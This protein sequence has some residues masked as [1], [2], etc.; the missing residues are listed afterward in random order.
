M[1]F[2]RRVSTVR[3]SAVAIAGL[4]LAIAAQTGRG[5][6]IEYQLFERDGEKLELL[7][8]GKR[9]YAASDF[10][11]STHNR[12]GAFY[13]YQKQLP[14]AKGF[15]ISILD[16][17]DSHGGFGITLERMPPAD[18]GFS[19]EWYDPAALGQFVKRQGGGTINV[20]FAASTPPAEVLS[21]EFLDAAD[22]RH[23]A[24]GLTSLFG[25]GD[26]FV[27]RVK[28]GSVLELPPAGKGGGDRKGDGG[29]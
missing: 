22:L 28:A 14:V 29:N 6:T 15:A 10:E 18:P 5:A 16:T 12:G 8:S 2:I 24:G 27:L 23:E 9:E 1:Q 21:I 20:K 3:L 19:W 11:L 17:L 13:G 26:E 4:L 7:A 25:F